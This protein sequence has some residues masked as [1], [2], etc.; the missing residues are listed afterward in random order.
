MTR[1]TQHL[2]D[3]DRYHFD[4]GPCSYANGFYQIDTD[5]DAWYFG[6]WAN[7]ATRTT[8]SFTEGDVTECQYDTDEEFTAAILANADWHQKNGYAFGIDPGISGNQAF[9]ARW[10]ALGLAH[11]LH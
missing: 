11:L 7:P 2:Q 6:Q 4:F 9:V 10:T 1:K 8:V 5:Q 3:A